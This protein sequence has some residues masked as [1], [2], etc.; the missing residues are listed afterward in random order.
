MCGIAGTVSK[1]PITQEQRARV[2]QINALLA[3]RGPDGE[4]EYNESHVALAMRRLSIIDL[5]SGWQPLY[6]EDK[7]LAIVAN[8]EI[9]NY[10]ELRP[11]LE[12]RGH[13]FQTHSDI[14]NILHLYEDY[15]LDCLS[16]L[17]G[18]FVFA[19]WDAKKQRLF[20][21]RDRMG[22]K[23]LY[24][25][26][27]PG[28]I[29]FASEL[30]ALL[31][32]G[33]VPLNLDPIAINHYFHYQYVPEPMTPVKDVR[34]LPAGHFLTIDVNPWKVTQSC[35]W[36][37]EDAEPIEGDPAK[38]LQAELER[39][40]EIVIRSD[41]PLGVALSGGID[42]SAVA[43]MAV[44]KYP[45]TLRAFSVG[46]PGH[47]PYDERD[48]AKAMAD[49]LGIPFHDVELTTEDMVDCFPDL[50]RWRDDPIADISGYGYYAVMK[51]AREH[52][53]PV[54]LQGQGGDELF[55]GYDWVQQAVQ[56][57]FQK[58][59]SSQPG[60]GAF[61]QSLELSLPQSLSRPGLALWLESLG[62][63]LPS[64]SRYRRR[65]N[66]P[67]EQLVF[68][69]LARDFDFASRHVEEL[70]T[71]AFRRSLNGVSPFSIFSFSQPWPRPDV[72]LTRLIS[73][74]YLLEN[75]VVQG[76]RLSMASSVELRLPLLDHQFVETVI[77]LRKAQPDHHLPPK[78][79]LKEVVK[80][81][82]PP[83]LLDRPKRGFEPPVHEWHTALFNA[84][85]ERLVDGYLVQ[86]E[87]LNPENARSLALGPY[88]KR[89][90]TPL[91]FKA[92]VLEMW[93]RQMAQVDHAL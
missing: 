81:V 3:H 83:G 79:R 38:I 71:P 26:E 30:K 29:T 24:L 2:A 87:I 23:P 72:L 86:N 90:N 22:E 43:A 41:V 49:Y 48:D 64:W 65:T 32:S 46:Y 36:R 20:L 35:Y 10:L 17:R 37:M 7:T 13:K 75:G 74:T 78:Y 1:E 28:E 18:M 63:L 4:G 56:E 31:P 15:G 68:Y 52:G 61:L 77:G 25:V 57:S 8:G 47:P 14:E 44:E 5:D 55:W 27:R 45:G 6:N 66:G 93:A 60:V 58:A 92:L 42:S 67:R 16:Y 62:G 73:H 19:L 51:I 84:Y 76:D 70:F 33:S 34:K 12:K 91:S 39:V 40:S 89:V 53:V 59:G 9:Y 85:G 21:A 80:G 82:L 88:P 50:V 11:R 54:M 69:D